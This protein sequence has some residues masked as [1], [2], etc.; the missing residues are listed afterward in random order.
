L[1][2]SHNSRRYF[3]GGDFSDVA[4]VAHSE[5]GG[6]CHHS[7]FKPSRDFDWIPNS[8]LK[9]VKHSPKNLRR[10][11]L[12]AF[13]N[14]PCFPLGKRKRQQEAA[15]AME[16]RH[17]QFMLQLRCW[18]AIS[19]V[20]AHVACVHLSENPIL[21]RIVGFVGCSLLPLAGL[22]RLVSQML[23][24]ARTPQAGILAD[25]VPVNPLPVNQAPDERSAITCHGAGNICVG[26]SPVA[27]RL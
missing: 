10:L 3:R 21:I 1:G 2:H 24:S 4:S 15:I 11:L 5:L 16:A 25:P 13:K 19:A 18:G 8:I 9:Y 14:R 7:H 12:Y 17:Q 6:Q 20:V 27:K 23:L 26:S 22:D